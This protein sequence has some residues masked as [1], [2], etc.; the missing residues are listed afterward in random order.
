MA[1][2]SF[3]LHPSIYIVPSQHPRYYR[4]RRGKYHH[5]LGGFQGHSKFCSIINLHMGEGNWLHRSR[6]Q[7]QL[8]S[9]LVPLGLVSGTDI[10]LQP[11]PIQS[12]SRSGMSLAGMLNSPVQSIWPLQPMSMP[13]AVPAPLPVQHS[14]ERIH[15]PCPRI[16]IFW[17]CI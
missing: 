15:S 9:A 10:A 1:Q 8:W 7:S 14:M 4:W 16:V 2:T 6:F 3:I 13:A 11:P 12:R 17:L 5:W